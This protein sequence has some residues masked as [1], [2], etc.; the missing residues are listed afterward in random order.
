[1]VAPARRSGCCPRTMSTARRSPF[2]ERLPHTPCRASQLRAKQKRSPACRSTT[3]VPFIRHAR[4]R[5]FSNS[6]ARTPW[7]LLFCYR[8]RDG[9]R[10]WMPAAKRLQRVAC[11]GERH[12][13]LYRRPP[14]ARR[15]C[16]GSGRPGAGRRGPVTAGITGYRIAAYDVSAARNSARCRGQEVQG[17]R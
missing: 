12:V 5:A 10:L 11:R 7:A 15:N 13:A 4:A 14:E 17:R 2:G 6:P 9:S 1:M 3:H 8:N 16:D